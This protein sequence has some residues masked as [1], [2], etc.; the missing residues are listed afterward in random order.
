[1]D[2]N[3][4]LIIITVLVAGVVLVNGWTDAP[5]AIATVVS[6]KSMSPRAAVIMAAIF[7]FIGVLVMSF[8]S[9]DVADTIGKMVSFTGD[10]ALVA[11]AAALF[12]IVLWAVLAWY[13]GIPTSE[14][15][16]LIAGLTGAAIAQGSF[17][18]VN[19]E[20]WSKVLWGIGFST[21]AGFF[22]GFV[23]VKVIGRLFKNMAR[24]TANTFFKYAQIAGGA[25]MAFLHGAQD[26]LKFIGVFALGLC[27]ANG[28]KVPESFTIAPWTMVACS[29]IM[30][31]GTSIGGYRIIKAVG[32]DM[33][34]LEKYQG[35]A[36]DTAASIALLISTLIGFPVS[37]THTKTTAIMGVGASRR[38]SL[39]NWGVAKDM[40]LAWVLTFPM[41][42]LVGFIMAKIFLLIF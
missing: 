27:L 30:G 25:A 2:N 10:Q 14:S 9:Q 29:L 6:T 41:C 37:T 42:G 8:V 26:G 13:F 28:D 31:F 39:V 17:A 1:M 22:G 21:L 32:M 5:N 33:V 18:A 35:F 4:A 36:A 7:N 19:M 34:K 16:A 3:I 15:H 38:M 20:E 24:R 12:A 40:V 11:L 23:I